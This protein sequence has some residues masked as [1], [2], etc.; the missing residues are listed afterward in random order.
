MTTEF[1]FGV[2]EVVSNVLFFF[3][4]SVVIS[5]V[6]ILFR[7]VEI[8]LGTKILG[9]LEVTFCFSV[10]FTVVNSKKTDNLM[11]NPIRPRGKI[12]FAI[13]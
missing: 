3:I 6:P 1:R 13:C 10:E 9:I 7:F 11:I 5:S 8:V 4:A 2:G 12:R